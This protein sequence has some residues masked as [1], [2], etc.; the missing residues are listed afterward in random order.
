MSAKRSP[1]RKKE[2][3]DQSVSIAHLPRKVILSYEHAK[4]AVEE[5]VTRL[6]IINDDEAILTLEPI[7]NGNFNLWIGRYKEVEVTLNNSEEKA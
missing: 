5:Y 7:K 4:R 3:A 6:S 1:K 2:S